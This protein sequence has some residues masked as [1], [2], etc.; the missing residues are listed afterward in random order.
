MITM[1]QNTH[2]FSSRKKKKKSL[3][4]S[5]S[6]F[7]LAYECFRISSRPFIT[8]STVSPSLSLIYLI[9]HLSIVIGFEE[10]FFAGP[11]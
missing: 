6:P 1:H 9:L 11:C 7:L 8:G 2:F 4:I 5:C 3:V 10:M